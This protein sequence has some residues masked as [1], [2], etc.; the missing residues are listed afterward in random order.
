MGT[1]PA[2]PARLPIAPTSP[3]PH[4]LLLPLWPQGEPAGAPS[5]CPAPHEEA[6]CVPPHNVGTRLSPTDQSQIRRA[7]LQAL[8]EALYDAARPH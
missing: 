4:Q 7:L 2:Q 1:I 5:L 8:Q 6:I 3:L